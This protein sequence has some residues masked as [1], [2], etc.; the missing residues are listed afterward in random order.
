MNGRRIATVGHRRTVSSNPFR[1][2]QISPRRTWMDRR[3]L[4]R[5]LV[6]EDRRKAWVHTLAGTNGDLSRFGVMH[7]C[8]DGRSTEGDQKAEGQNRTH[9]ICSSRPPPVLIWRAGRTA[10]IRT[11][12]EIGRIG[13]AVD[14]AVDHQG[15]L[16][17]GSVRR[18]A[19]TPTMEPGFRIGVASQ[20]ARRRT[21]RSRCDSLS[22]KYTCWR[23]RW[24]ASIGSAASK[25]CGARASNFRCRVL[26]GVI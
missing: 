15:H 7:P 22:R 21:V 26:R 12:F 4:A 13:H 14:H 24:S 19:T 2:P 23:P 3:S 9:R 5:G 16:R 11:C 10:A 17:S 25:L 6:L 8:G 20:N 18:S 1:S